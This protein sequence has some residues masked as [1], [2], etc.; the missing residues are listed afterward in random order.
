M[1]DKVCEINECILCNS[2]DWE[3]GWFVRILDIMQNQR[4]QYHRKVWEHAVIYHALEERGM[5][6]PG[7]RGLG[8]GVG[9][10][11]LPAMFAAHGCEIVA[12]DNVEPRAWGMQYG[13]SIADLR[14]PHLCP[15][16]VF[17]ELVTYRQVDMNRIPDDLR[18]FD[19]VWSSC[20]MEHIGGLGNGMDFCC[21][22]IRCIRDGGLSVHTT[23][24]NLDSN[25]ATLESP[26]VN[27]YRERDLRRMSDMISGAGGLMYPMNLNRPMTE[28]NAHVDETT[29]DQMRHVNVRVG[30]FAT[31]SMLI[32][33]ERCNG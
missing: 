20:S 12:T 27:I 11:P 8:F 10:E 22:T 25:N 2:E 17:D 3:K 24:Y 1:L 23:E 9:R 15:D 6:A 28:L 5:L 26:D 19:F 16:D 32:I 29:Q 31:T 33:C 21:N 14:M 4:N 30:G 7:K 13:R 18:G